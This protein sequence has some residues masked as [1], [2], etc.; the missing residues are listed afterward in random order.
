MRLYFVFFYKMFVLLKFYYTT[1]FKI[2]TIVGLV[3]LQN[4]KGRRL[5]CVCIESVNKRGPRSRTRHR[6]IILKAAKIAK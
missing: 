5:K 4:T 3:L 1:L 2:V 6:Y